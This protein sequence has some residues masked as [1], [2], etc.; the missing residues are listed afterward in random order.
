MSSAA[1]PL[2]PVLYNLLVKKFGQVKISSEGC[3][4]HYQRIP[5]PFNPGRTIEQAAFWGEYYCV[6]CP[7][8]NDHSPRLWI[9]HLYASEV[10]DGRRQ[11]THL[12]VCYNNQCLSLP[13]RREQLEQLIFGMGAHLRPRALPVK[14]VTT[15]YVPKPVTAPGTIVPLRDLPPD[16]PAREY[17]L[18]R[19][20]D[21][22]K[23]SD[24]FNIGFVADTAEGVSLACR[25]RIYIPVVQNGD[26]LG[27][28]CRGITPDAKPKYLNAPAMHKASLLYN[29]DTAR[30][31]PFVIVVEGV[32]SVWRLGAASVCLFGKSLSMAQHNLIVRTWNKKPVFLMLDKD[33]QVEM[34]HAATLLRKTMAH[35]IT[36]PL[37][38]ARDPADYSFDEITD[39]VFARAEAEGVL[40]LMV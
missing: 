35:V 19:R 14:A 33:A 24:S 2:N 28:Q 22:D 29:F 20:F 11:F 30:E 40:S 31:Q 39:I 15:P 12:A 16:H 6:R 32:P 10:K 38:D 5:D 18:S 4:A 7:F 3:H 27:W 34:Q 37:P 23:L 17:L 8:C 13:G 25:G 9:N 21:P 1:D 36:I 26:L